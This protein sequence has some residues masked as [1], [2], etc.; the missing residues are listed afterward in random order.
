MTH[1]SIEYNIRLGP[2]LHAPG[3]GEEILA[4][5][6]IA[7]EDEGVQAEVAK[8]KLPEGTKI[9]VDPWI[10]GTFPLLFDDELS[11]FDRF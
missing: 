4:I 6:Q 7:I 5:E 2:N 1:Q 10:Y 3:D 11:D 8:L 9:V